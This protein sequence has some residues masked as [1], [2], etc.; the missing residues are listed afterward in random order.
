MTVSANSSH[1]FLALD[2][3]RGIA[4]VMVIF[5][6]FWEMSNPSDDRL[7][8]WWFFCAGHEAVIL[9]FVLSGFVLSHQLRSFRFINYYQ[10]AFKRIL[11]IYPAYYGAIIFSA[12]MFLYISH[13]H[14]AT[15]EGYG[16]QPWFYIWSQTKFDLTMWLGSITLMF[17]EGSSLD[18][19]TWSLFYEMWL[20][21]AF[22]FLLW[23][24]F[25][26]HYGLRAVVF[27]FFAILSVWFWREG[28]FLDNAWQ[29]IIYYG[30]YFVVGMII[31]HYHHHL[32]FFARWEWLVV[33][34]VC[35][36]SNYLLF[37]KITSRLVHEIIIAG[38]S[39]LLIINALH[40]E[41]F[42]KIMQIAPLQFYGKISYSIYLY[43]L[44]ILYTASYLLL[45]H[46]G[47]LPLK[48]LIF[49]VSSLIATISYFG[50][51]KYFIKLA[52]RLIKFN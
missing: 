19:A 50:C 5:Q 49:I 9:F 3:L 44:P 30:W 17:H 37:G 35:Y 6:H 7:R 25:R 43:H 38:G 26:A 40:Y 32:R 34:C 45:G 51:E 27:I 31:Y 28:A 46:I 48:I 2:S 36:F 42:Q 10:F 33:G 11:R 16:L 23:L 22:P 24:L 52:N 8:P 39:A 14:A 21:L 41:K 13:Y 4:A 1:K 18:L 12:I 29:G 20:S 15:L 47:L